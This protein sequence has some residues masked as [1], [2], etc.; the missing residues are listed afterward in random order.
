MKPDADHLYGLPLEQ[1]T[2]ARN[3]AARELRRSGDRQAAEEIA[4]LKKPTKPAWAINQLVRQ[5]LASI[6]QVLKAGERLRAAQEGALGGGSGAK[7]RDAATREREAVEQAASRVMEIL[8]E[9]L[10]ASNL[11]RVR[12]SLH[13]AA[14][15]EDVRMEIEA[16]RLTSDHEPIGLGSFAPAPGP[17]RGVEE[18]RPRKPTTKQQAATR[19]ELAEARKADRAATRTV[20]AARRNLAS[21][22][23]AA[24][25]AQA[26][27]AE[28]QAGLA[29]AEAV[30]GEAAARLEQLE[31]EAQRGG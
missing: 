24:E 27:L 4:R 30:A 18:K 7:L 2:G 5:D 11:Q 16:G 12:N 17:P 22:R 20:E 23:D 28:A 29:E 15:D 26:R 10:S 19:R 14:S 9:P 8:E 31:K 21:H 6:R 25:R 13:A 3:D 1:F